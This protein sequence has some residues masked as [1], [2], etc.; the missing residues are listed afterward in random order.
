ME[1]LTAGITNSSYWVVGLGSAAL[2]LLALICL[3]WKSMPSSAK[4]IF[5]W[6]IVISVLVPTTFLTTG[7]VYVNQKSISR[8]PVHW[9]ADFQIWTCGQRLDLLDPTGFSNKIGTPL[10]HEHNDERIHVEGPI[11][12][13]G[14]VS[15]GNFFRVIGGFIDTDKMTLIG[16]NG[17]QNFVSGQNCPTQSVPSQVQ[18]FVYKTSPDGVI[19]QEKLVEPPDYT[20]SPQGNV[21]P[22]DCIIVEYAPTKT[23]TD[24]IC[25]SYEVGLRTGKIKR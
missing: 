1:G 23:E 5:F 21:P 25:Q 10:L 7:T 2:F 22:G 12:T 18:V 16:N 3:T 9:H 14:E 11:L 6:L 4:P 13:E 17:A 8:G 15:L 24:K 20:L 19:S